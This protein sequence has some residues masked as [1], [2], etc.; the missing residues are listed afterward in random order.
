MNSDD[1]YTILQKYLWHSVIFLKILNSKKKAC[2][3]YIFCHNKRE[4]ISIILKYTGQ[5]F[6]K[7]LQNIYYLIVCVCV[8][9]LRVCLCVLCLCISTELGNR[10]ELGGVS[11][12]FPSHES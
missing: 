11:S 8:C 2:D 12:F 5:L 4:I 10:E 7:L 1:S 9:V 3:V 6:L